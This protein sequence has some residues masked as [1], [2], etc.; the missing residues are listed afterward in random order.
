MVQWV[1][2][3][4]TGID[5]IDFTTAPGDTIHADLTIE[6]TDYPDLVFVPSGGQTAS[7]S[8]L[9]IDLAPDSK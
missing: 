6:G 5:G 9:P 2:Q 3:T 7:P 8:C 1:T 4:S